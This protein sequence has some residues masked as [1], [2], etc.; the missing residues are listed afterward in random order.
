MKAYQPTE[1]G[2]SVVRFFQD[3]LPTLRGMSR[4]TIRSYRDAMI[5]FLGFCAEDRQRR[6][7]RLELPDINADRVVRFL[8]HLEAIL[9]R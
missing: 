4:H 7:E 3:Y 9:F 2:R 1:L 8:A 5:L 6:V